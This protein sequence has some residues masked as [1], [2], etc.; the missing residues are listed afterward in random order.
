MR[1]ADLI[2]LVLIGGIV[3]FIAAQSVRTPK[4]PRGRP[5]PTDTQPMTPVAVAP[6]SATT[7][8]D[9]TVAS[10]TAAQVDR[11]P[12][13]G[14]VEVRL[15]SQPAP[16]RDDAAIK[17]TI[18]AY[19]DRTYLR[20]ILREQEQLLMRWPARELNALRVWI[21]RQPDVPGWDN[22]YLL[23]AEGVFEEWR[24][25]GFPLSFNFVH[26]SAGSDIH[27][28]WTTKLASDDARR[29]GSTTKTRDQHGWI[30]AAEITVS[31][32]DPHGQLLAP[33]T[34]AGVLRHEVG[35]ALGLGHSGSA[36]DVMYPESR[37]PIIS[38]AD[39]STLNVLY[40]LP[41][42]VVK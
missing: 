16:R 34:I 5:V 6:Q 10:A 21:D 3:A 30:T 20:A 15:S 36:A 27:L 8:A 11:N 37:T 35:H 39:R 32:Q 26:D 31:M 2:P 29:I 18:E 7:T 23:V 19:A 17:A 38:A 22:R 13:A 33:E 14:M 24:E 41:P 4:R 25:A 1:R 40:R 42:G 28:L 9:T 12:L